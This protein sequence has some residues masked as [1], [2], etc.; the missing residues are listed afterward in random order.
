[1][2]SMAGQPLGVAAAGLT[3]GGLT[4]V[5][6]CA[7]LVVEAESGVGNKGSQGVLAP[8][9]PQHP[10]IPP[11]HKL[12]LCNVS[13]ASSTLFD[14][15]GHEWTAVSIPDELLTLACFSRSSVR[16]CSHVMLTH[17]A[18]LSHFLVPFPGDKLTGSVDLR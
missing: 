13:R 2:V 9:F 17:T 12:S 3:H 11:P 7:Q 6:L 1:M 16:C 14:Q 10:S 8:P 4:C 5:F 15:V 18:P